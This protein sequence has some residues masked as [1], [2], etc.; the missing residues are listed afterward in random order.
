MDEEA[1]DGD[2][3]LDVDLGDLAAAAAGAGAEAGATTLPKVS[4]AS[5]AEG[6]AGLDFVFSGAGVDLVD[7]VE[8][9]GFV[10]GAF[11]VG[12]A[13]A[14][15]RRDCNADFNPFVERSRFLS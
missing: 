8:D 4:T 5:E 9:G 11:C 3:D 13:S 1:E 7:L 10:A 2:V 12:A 15:T 6:A 14:S